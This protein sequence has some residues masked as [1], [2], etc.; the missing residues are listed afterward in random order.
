MTYQYESGRRRFHTKPD[1]S[2]RTASRRCSRSMKSWS[3]HGWAV[4]TADTD[5]LPNVGP[6]EAD[7]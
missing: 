6:G 3:G 1:A 5:C 7:S 4:Y 2:F